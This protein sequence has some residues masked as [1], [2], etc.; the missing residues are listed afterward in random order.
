MKITFFELRLFWWFFTTL[1]V[2][3]P[4]LASELFMGNYFATPWHREKQ[5][6]GR[7][8][9]EMHQSLNYKATTLDRPF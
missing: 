2:L 9:G 5:V 4:S 8:G 6:K 3:P 7:E 1:R